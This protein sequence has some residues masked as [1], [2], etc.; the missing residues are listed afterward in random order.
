MRSYQYRACLLGVVCSFPAFAHAANCDA[1]Q[2]LKLP[3]TTITLAQKTTDVEGPDIDAPAHGLPEFCRVAGVLRPSADSEIHFELWLPETGWNG[4]FL[5]VGNGGF[6][7]S[8]GYRQLAGN[9]RRGY[10]TA[11]SDAGHMAD[12]EDATWAFGHPEKIKD[13]GWRAVHLTT[14]RAKEIVASYYGKP[15]AKAY[16]DGCSDGGREALMEAQRFPEDYDGIL[17][18]APANNWAHML[19]SGA[20]VAQETRGDPHAYIS[21]M[22]L[23]AIQRA[24]LA[25]CDARDGVK[26]G[27]I[28]DPT[29]CRFDPGVLLCKRADSLDCLTRPQVDSLKK[30]YAG[31]A[32]SHGTTIFPG[33][34]LGDETSWRDWIVGGGPGAG[35]GDQY[36]QNY[37]RYMVTGDPK[38][39]ILTANVD[40]L[41]AQAVGATSAELDSTNPDLTSFAARGGRLIIYHGWNDPA[42]SPWNSID[43]YKS[44]RKQMGE[45]KSE[46]FFRLY[47]VPGM[48]HC[49][50]G[51]GPDF[52]GQLGL[53]TSTEPKFGVFDALVDWV[54]QNVPAGA[55]TATK[56]A[57]GAN[58]ENRVKMMRPLCAYP[59]MAK[60]KGDGD[61]NDAASFICAAPAI[62]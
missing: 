31:G 19:T 28:G 54:E 1:I 3:D 15:A 51:P 50:G 12:A 4:R 2:D 5:G 40:A 18:G 29:K 62:E 10:A 16:F 37:F 8:I 7:G 35:Y 11:G 57:P 21:S 24:T 38:F 9:L 25:E 46:S 13:F 26:D 41:L 32:D 39:N 61:T 33:F 53:P 17:A 47:M 48:E 60:Y 6:A 22:K 43:Y 34:A 45:Q 55:V 49:V 52:F 30:F 20:A 42:I 58:G 23:A 44:V 14:E 36:V 56:Y 27:I 59:E